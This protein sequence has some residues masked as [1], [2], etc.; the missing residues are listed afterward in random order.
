MIKPA[1]SRDV[2]VRYRPRGLAG[3][4]HERTKSRN[5]TKP[6]DLFVLSCFRGPCSAVLLRSRKVHEMHV[7]ANPAVWLMVLGALIASGIRSRSQA[8]SQDELTLRV[9][10]V[11]SPEK[12]QR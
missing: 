6:L 4:R 2:T 3:I 7:R 1:C 8:P 10:V 9:I 5:L 12:A 11:D